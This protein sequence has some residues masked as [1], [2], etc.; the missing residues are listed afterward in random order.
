[1]SYAKQRECPCESPLR[2][3][4]LAMGIALCLALPWA[5]G[6]S[7]AHAA[8]AGN[9]TL[10]VGYPPGG[11]TDVL[12]RVIAEGLREQTGTPV[13][14]ENKPGAGGRIATEQVKN[15]RSDGSILLF[16]ISSPMVIFPHI[17]DQ[18]PYDPLEDFSPIGSVAR[19]GMA[20]S[21][22]PGVP[23]TV[24]TVADYVQWVK[25]NPQAAN[26]GAV[27][28][29]APHFA[30]L[31]FTQ[32][33]NL[34]LEMIPYKGGAQIITDLLG[35]HLSTAV[36]PASEVEPHHTAGKLR[37]LATL[38]PERSATLPQVPTMRE[39][40]YPD[41]DFQT[42]I[43]LLGPEGM[44]PEVVDDLNHSLREVLASDQAKAG[45]AKLGMEPAAATPAEFAA[46]IE[47]DYD[48]FKHLVEASGFKAAD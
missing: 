28:G 13:I 7:A 9:L 34:D 48:K 8:S 26:F 20:L 10:V 15:A 32:A 27:S 2:R 4:S 39:A 18:L 17:Y 25:A 21:V 23:E 14:V 43:G 30:G 16:S 5:G 22:G 24:R 46:M 42:W 45:I 31:L 6:L 11:A 3:R 40:G 47:N 44:A 12:A 35:G 41:V 19:L 1:M 29:A 36:T 37:V 38:G 33:A